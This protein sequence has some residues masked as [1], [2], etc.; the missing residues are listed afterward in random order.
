MKGE[1]LVDLLDI[2]VWLKS[3]TVILVKRKML[4][5]SMAFKSHEP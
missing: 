5:N 2:K 3:M 1:L 4:I